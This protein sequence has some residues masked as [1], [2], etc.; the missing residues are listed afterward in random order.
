MTHMT[1]SHLIRA[2]TVDDKLG[3]DDVTILGLNYAPESSGIAPYTSGLANGLASLGLRVNVTTG[4]PHY[5]QWRIHRGFSGSTVKEEYGRLHITRLRHYV[6]R[7]PRLVNR[8][9]ME[10]SYALRAVLADWKSPEI[11]IFV[12]PALFATGILSLRAWLQRLPTCVWV[13]DIYSLGVTETGASGSVSASLLRIVESTVLRRA[14]RV[15]VIHDRFKRYLV[16]SLGVDPKNITVIRNWSHNTTAV[17]DDRNET[18]RSFG[19]RPEDVIVLH[20]GNMGAKQNLENVVLASRIAE[21][22]G[23]HV[24]F[25]LLG[26]GNQRGK[27]E[28]MGMNSHLQFIRSLP[29]GEFERALAAADILLVNE[30]PGLT[31]MS[32]PSKLTAYFGSGLPVIAATDK[33]SVTSEELA[34]AGAGVQVEPAKPAA[35]LAA[36]EELSANGGRAATFGVAG[37]KFRATY[38]SERVAIGDFCAVLRKAL[39]EV[40]G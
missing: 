25:V 7:K 33:T 37:A 13:Q 36:A 18:R 5:P 10:V 15:V 34:L 14:S 9:I 8:L 32:V 29:D 40:C 23:S 16:R 21:E 31:E 19:W 30:R 35:L 11:V 6:P 4:F 2:L 24:R 22:R 26:D 20:A 3:V 27:L 12:T 39:S 1:G 17:D 38:L 28:S